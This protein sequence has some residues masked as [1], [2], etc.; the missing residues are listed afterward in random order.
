MNKG[1]RN[2]RAERRV[3]EVLVKMRKEIKIPNEKSLDNKAK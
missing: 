1:G 3:E 2:F